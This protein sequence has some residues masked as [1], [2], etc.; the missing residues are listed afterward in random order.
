MILEIITPIVYF[1]FFLYFISNSNYFNTS[2]IS[3]NWWMIIFSSKVFSALIYGYLFI[4]GIII[5]ND[6]YAFFYDSDIVFS[7]LK[8]AP[9]TYLELVFGR[10]DYKPV[11]EHLLYYTNNTSYWFDMSNYFLVRIN[12]LLRIISLGIYNVHAIFFA[13]LSFIGFYHLYLFFENKVRDKKTLQFILF[14]IPSVIFWTSGVHKEALVVFSIGITLYNIDVIL[15]LK[16]SFLN[17]LYVIIGL[18]V[19]GFSR[20]YLFAFILPLLLAVYLAEKFQVKKYLLGLFITCL[21]IP[22]FFLILIDVLT[23]KVSF[24]NEFLVRRTFFLESVGNTSFGLHENLNNI[25]GILMLFLQAIVNPIIR[26]LPGDNNA[27]LSYVASLET[28]CLLIFAIT[29]IRQTSFKSI[30]QNP[31]ALF[32]IIFGFSSLVLIGFIVNN[33]GAIVRYRA[34]PILF[35]LLGFS[36]KKSKKDSFILNS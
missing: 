24:I 15:K 26:P 35:I 12:A 36:L 11:P 2:S 5:G 13:F 23:P 7:A 30:I 14:G 10:N 19:L 29:L 31:Y 21:V 22:I 16:Y 8:N 33:S 1:V 17:I 9:L 27:L 4:S 32:S 6:T 25:H 34:V 18:V 3:K 20:I 28:I